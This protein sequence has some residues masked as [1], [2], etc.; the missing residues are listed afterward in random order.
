M[1]G[2]YGAEYQRGKNYGKKE[3][4]DLHSGLLEFIAENQAVNAQG[5]TPRGYAKKYW[6]S[7]MNHPRA[8]SGI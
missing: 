5:E 4:L 8:Y 6:E 1:A 3:F 7:V 2:I